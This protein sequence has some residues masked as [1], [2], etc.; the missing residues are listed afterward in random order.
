MQLLE[1]DTQLE[2]LHVAVA[3]L[4]AEGLGAG[5]SITGESGVG[6]TSLVNAACAA[7]APGIRVLRVKCDPLETPRPLGPVKDL[8]LDLTAVDA[9]PAQ[10]CEQV[11]AELRVEPTILVVEDLHWIDAASA[12]VLRFL[13]RRIE[14]TALVLFFTMRDNEIG[15]THVARPLLGDVATLDGLSSVSLPPLSLTAVG[16]LLAGTTMDPAEVHA[17]TGGNPFFVTEVAKEPDRPMPS[18]IR[19]AILARTTALSPD[20]LGV[21]QLMATAPDQLNDR[22]LPTLGIDLPTLRRLNETTLIDRTENGIVFRHELA[23]RAI[24]STIP[25]GGTG[26]LHARLLV[27]LEGL[28]HCDPAVLTH[29]AVAAHDSARAIVHAKAAA[30]EATRA[31]AHTEAVAFYKIAL[32]QSGSTPT[33]ERADLLLALAFQQ[34]M[35]SRLTDAISSVQQG[36]PVWQAAGD[37]DGI[38]KAHAA[39]GVYEYYAAHRQRAESHLDRAAA[40]AIDAG[41]Q[42]TFGHA[43]TTRA[44][45]AYMRSDDDLTRSCLYDSE[46]VPGDEEFLRLRNLVVGTAHALV[47]GHDHARIDMLDHIDAARALGFDELASTGY[48]NIANLDVE[49]GRYR[50]AER[51]LSESLPFTV[52]RDIPI[53]RHWQTAVRSRL[54]LTKGH[55]N[56]ALEDASAVLVDDGMP[57]AALWPHLVRTLVPLRR[58]DDVPLDEL[59][60]AWVLADDLDEPLRKLAVLAALAEVSWTTGRA[61]PRLDVAGLTALMSAPGAGWAAGNLLV[62]C[63]RLGVD[64]PAP[65][66]LPEPFRLMLDDRPADAASWWK[67]AGDPFAEALAWSDSPA[68]DDR[69]R[70]V[71]LLDR[72]GALGTADRLREVLRRGGVAAVPQRPRESTRANP[73]GLTNRQLDVARLVARGLTNAEIAAR[74]YI[75]PKT[76]DH[77]VSAILTKLGVPNRRAVIARAEEMGL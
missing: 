56:A 22:I 60:A 27:A 74:L 34:Y 24:E 42:S 66:S 58:G 57:I 47:S 73:G 23:R 63:R 72:L 8:G 75:S 40:I 41:A 9:L 14:A 33:R 36:F 11:Y 44:Y 30:A 25:A 64:V 55:W 19:D 59:D 76:A 15:P 35:T 39:I 71:E 31:G 4:D 12:D 28:D 67:L 54:R 49:H 10:V 17:T 26:R 20:D 6:K 38:A 65:P 51:I 32:E 62:W 61:D 1:R 13:V 68:A 18:S 45:L 5:I 52:E 3:R 21:L 16:E 7:A 46:S 37:A 2:R 29:H 48:S 69:V 50:D 77:H 70:A 43:R 53:C